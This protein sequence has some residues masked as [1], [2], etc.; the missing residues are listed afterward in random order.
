M[1]IWYFMAILAFLWQF[2]YFMAIFVL[3]SRF[4]VLHLEN[5]GNLASVAN[6]YVC[7]MLSQ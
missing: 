6:S 4:G 5:S 7:K 3:Y 1:A 2:W